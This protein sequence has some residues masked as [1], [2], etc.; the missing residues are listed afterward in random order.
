M[1]LSPGVL[2]L[3]QARVFIPRIDIPLGLTALFVTGMPLLFHPESVRWITMLFTGAW[4]VYFMMLAR[5]VRA[6]RL[7]PSAFLT[8]I[9]W[10]VYAFAAMLVVQ[11]LCVI[12]GLP[13][14]NAGMVYQIPFKLNSL[15]A[16][17]SHTTVTLSALMFFYTWTLRVSHHQEPL[18]TSLRRD[19]LLWLCYAWTIFTTYNSS[20][21][22]IGPLCLLPYLTKRNVLPVAGVVTIVVLIV[23]LSPVGDLWLVKRLRDTVIATATFNDEAVMKADPSASARIVPTFRGARLIDPTDP[24][25]YVGHGVDADKHDTAPRPTD[26]YENGFA[27][28][29]SM[30]HNYGA[31]AAIAFWTAIG[32]VTLTRRRWL[33]LVSFL[34]A[35]QMS[36]DYN[37]QLVW[38]I[39][40]FSMVFKF[41]VCGDRRLL[42]T[43]PPDEKQEGK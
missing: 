3:K 31:P 1:C 14:I 10:V 12:F 38:M 33:S 30:W 9:R 16:E 18:A 37:M 21:F 28:V 32:M 41:T 43:I 17:P 35:M 2:L 23:N 5:L 11:Q 26:A 24:D 29:F 39:M 22:L 15:T 25:M 19:W 36:A 40:A 42:A 7:T 8:I 6:A 13:V 34:F 20:A 27:G 4:C